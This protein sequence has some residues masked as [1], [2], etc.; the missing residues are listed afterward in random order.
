MYAPVSPSYTPHSRHQ[1]PPGE[2]ALRKLL[3]RGTPHALGYPALAAY[4]A[5][6]FLGAAICCG[7]LLPAGEGSDSADGG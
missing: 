1:P 2:D 3:T 7:T 4:G 5:L 6:Y